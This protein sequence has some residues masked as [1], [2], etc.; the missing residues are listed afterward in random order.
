M[1]SKNWNEIKNI[2]SVELNTRLRELQDKFFKLKFRHSSVPLKNPLEVREMRRNIAR[3]K[4]F[5]MLKKKNLE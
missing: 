3:I 4:T 5:I 1:K 2:S